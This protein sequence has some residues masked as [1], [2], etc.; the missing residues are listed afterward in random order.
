MAV[1]AVMYTKQVHEVT[2]YKATVTE[3]IFGL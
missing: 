1:G 2:K 3:I